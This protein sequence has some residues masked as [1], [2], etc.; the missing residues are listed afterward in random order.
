MASQQHHFLRLPQQGVVAQLFQQPLDVLPPRHE[1][2]NRTRTLK[3]HNVGENR[4]HQVESAR[5]PRPVLQRVLGAGGE[6]GVVGV[7]E[8]LSGDRGDG[9]FF[10]V[11]QSLQLLEALPFLAPPVVVD[12]VV[13]CQHVACHLQN[14]FQKKGFH[15]VGEALQT[16]Y[17]FEPEAEPKE[18]Q[19]L[20]PSKHIFFFESL[21]V[22]SCF[23]PNTQ[24]MRRLF[25][26]GFRFE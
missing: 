9:G 5:L 7:E 21:K 23:Y 4:L 2:Q 14:V 24:R 19:T 25:A 3:A 16:P 11:F 15:G 18:S 13:G 6:V 17:R 26:H 1:H 8:S 22:E 20:L 10:M 12:L